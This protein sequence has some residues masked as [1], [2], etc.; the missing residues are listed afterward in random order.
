MRI[1]GARRTGIINQVW[2]ES[3]RNSPF[4]INRTMSDNRKTTKK[5]KRATI[6]PIIITPIIFVLIASVVAVP[7]F[8]K[9]YSVLEDIVHEAQGVLSMS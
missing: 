4:S 2:T 3:T 9:V 7:V 5:R 1:N 6:R 8:L